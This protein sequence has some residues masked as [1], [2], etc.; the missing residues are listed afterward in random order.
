[1]ILYVT[2]CV[3]L[4]VAERDSTQQNEQRSTFYTLSLDGYLPDGGTQTTSIRMPKLPYR[5]N[6]HKI[7]SDVYFDIKESNSIYVSWQMFRSYRSLPCHIISPHKL[8]SSIMS[9]LSTKGKHL[10]DEINRRLACNSHTAP[11]DK[12]NLCH[13]HLLP[14]DNAPLTPYHYH[15]Y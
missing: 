13:G 9:F 5:Q 2:G 10:A 12:I 3:C 14:L 7:L 1:M 8:A 15:Y 11:L 4:F 6:A